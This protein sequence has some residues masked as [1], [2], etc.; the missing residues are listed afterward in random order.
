VGQA[1]LKLSI[2]LL[3]PPRYWD[4]VDAAGM[5]HFREIPQSL[6][7][8]SSS[9][10]T[11]GHLQRVPCELRSSFLTARPQHHGDGAGFLCS[12]LQQTDPID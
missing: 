4:S 1:G 5:L 10:P 7:K 2:L 6:R 12:L 3:Q 9:L 8:A 11:S